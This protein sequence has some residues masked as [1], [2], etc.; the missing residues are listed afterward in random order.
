M[1]GRGPG[2]TAVSWLQAAPGQAE[3]RMGGRSSS[4]S[5][6]RCRPCGGC[7]ALGAS[8]KPPTR[9]TAPGQLAVWV[10]GAV[11]SHLRQLS[12]GDDS[13]LWARLPLAASIHWSG[14]GWAGPASD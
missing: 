4:L 10:V 13:C 1:G 7:P 9:E 12:A 3:W 8:W 14:L 5:G 6:W 11:R 2:S